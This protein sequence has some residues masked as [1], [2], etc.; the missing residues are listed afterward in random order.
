MATTTGQ[1]VGI[2]I[3]AGAMV[4]GT[5][6][7]FVAMI[8]APKNE[9]ADAARQQEEYNKLIADMK[10]KQR[11]Q[12]KPLKGYEAEKFDAASVKELKVK[13]LK[14]GKGDKVKATDTINANYF[15]WDAS[16]SIFDSTNKKDA[17]EPAPIDFSLAEVI[18]G[19][20]EGLA[21]V[22]VGST[23]ELTIPAEKAYGNED[24][25]MGQ[26]TGPLKF[27]VKVEKIVEKEAKK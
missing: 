22:P 1:R 13:Y 15:G 17:K 25:G 20:T 9:A 10:K 7:G 16:G 26:P 6:A 2:W 4:I 24:T 5:L 3:I 23:V 21:G 14:K 19:W 18:K 11:E 8:L 27:I 12:N